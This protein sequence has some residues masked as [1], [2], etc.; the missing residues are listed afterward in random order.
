M[1]ST[2]SFSVE[3]VC[4]DEES[5][6]GL[7][8][9]D[10]EKPFQT[11]QKMGLDLGKILV[12]VRRCGEQAM[13]HIGGA[14]ISGV[15]ALSVFPTGV[16]TSFAFVEM[17]SRAI[18]SYI[19]SQ[20][21]LPNCPRWVIEGFSLYAALKTYSRFDPDGASKVEKYYAETGGRGISRIEDLRSWMYKDHPA[22][23]LIKKMLGEKAS[24][25]LKAFYSDGLDRKDCSDNVASM[26]GSAY[27]LVK[28]FL[29]SKEGHI[30]LRRALESIATTE[31]K[32][33]EKIYDIKA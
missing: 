27:I 13:I 4:M 33:E 30:D 9:G 18:S 32:C 14:S 19:Y 3:V 7:I 20:D 17:L 24:K 5:R 21:I 6:C 28:R 22:I 25:V 12:I 8:K 2:S 31:S 1:S 16:D 10:I 23:Q 26:R 11:L 15:N 29:E